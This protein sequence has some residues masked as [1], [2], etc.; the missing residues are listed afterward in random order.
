MKETVRSIIILLGL[1]LC[2]MVATA[3]N[4]HNVEADIERA[5]KEFFYKISEM[6][7]PIDPIR[8]ENIASAYLKGVNSFKVNGSAYK[9]LDFLNWYKI[10]V[11]GKQNI[12]HQARIVSIRPFPEKNRYYVETL[13]Q[14]KIE[15]DQQKRHIQ[16]ETVYLK[17]IWRGEEYNNVSIQSVSFNLKLRDQKPNIVKEYELSLDPIVSHLSSE[18]GDWKF[19][20]T[21]DVKSMEGFDGEE[22]TC[23]N[24]QSIGGSYVNPDEITINVDK[25]VFSGHIDRNKSKEARCFLVIVHQEESNKMVRHYIY[26]EGTKKK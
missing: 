23:V 2:P 10:N 18:G 20:L 12:I 3:Q 4:K 25:C 17:V 15:D 24:R 26:Q 22:R 1:Y 21:S 16:D 11:L 5:V 13:L 9:L 19:E 8:P 14:R 6:N 7:N